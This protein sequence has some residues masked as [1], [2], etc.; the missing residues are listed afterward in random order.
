MY[1]KIIL[2]PPLTHSYSTVTRIY[3]NKWFSR[4]NRWTPGGHA[5]REP[6]CGQRTDD[7][8]HAGPVQ[9]GHHA[10]Q[11]GALRPLSRRV[12]GGPETPTW[13]SVVR[14]QS[15][16][17]RTRKERRRINTENGPPSP[18]IVVVIVSYRMRGNKTQTRKLPKIRLTGAFK[19]P[20][21][22]GLISPC[23]GPN[24]RA[25]HSCT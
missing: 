15:G 20:R 24:G 25:Y 9:P 12:N 22:P 23:P 18:I 1:S 17:R 6:E 4:V 3:V 19:T 16:S 7:R 21:P 2:K 8:A 10:V 13:L 14:A 11:P 5:T